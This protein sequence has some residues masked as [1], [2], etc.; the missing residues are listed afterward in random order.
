MLNGGCAGGDAMMGVGGG[1]LMSAGGVDEPVGVAT[2][3]FVGFFLPFFGVFFGGIL[4]VRRDLV[5]VVGS[6]M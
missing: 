6:P 4:N 1:V 2:A 5:S 3:G